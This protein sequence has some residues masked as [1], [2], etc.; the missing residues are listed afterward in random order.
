MHQGHGIVR[1]QEV[2]TSGYVTKDDWG[3][4]GDDT[5]HTNIFEYPIP[6]YWQ[7]EAN[8]SK[9]KDPEFVDLIFYDQ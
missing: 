9:G 6:R 7:A 5:K 1:R 2:I 8:F 4:D 3:T